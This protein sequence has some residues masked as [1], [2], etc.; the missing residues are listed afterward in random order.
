MVSYQGT[1]RFYVAMKIAGII[2]RVFDCDKTKR[3]NIMFS[4]F[5]YYIK[6][7]YCRSFSQI[8]NNQLESA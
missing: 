2:A 6:P 7:F 8:D 5:V 4:A 1:R 3:E